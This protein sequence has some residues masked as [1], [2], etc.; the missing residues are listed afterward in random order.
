MKKILTICICLLLI[1]GCENNEE[2]QNAELSRS[3]LQFIDSIEFT[4]LNY[5]LENNEYKGNETCKVT[6]ELIDCSSGL[7]I[8]NNFETEGMI[9]EGIIDE[10]SGEI[11]INELTITSAKLT[12]PQINDSIFVYSNKNGNMTH[13][14]KKRY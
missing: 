2:Q 5:Y 10:V 9:K 8:N 6:P 12:F 7:T 1:S 3:A 14:I 4:L 11:I 13:T